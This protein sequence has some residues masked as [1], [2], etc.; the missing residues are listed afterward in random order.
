MACVIAPAV[1]HP[2]R[3]DPRPPVWTDRQSTDALYRDRQHFKGCQVSMAVLTADAS[4]N[5]WIWQGFCNPFISDNNPQGPRILL[6]PIRAAM[7]IGGGGVLRVC[8]MRS[9]Q[10][11]RSMARCAHSLLKSTGLF[12]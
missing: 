8:R 7:A 3:S 1:L 10:Q 12:R 4:K 11:R 9:R 2:C 5:P 6:R